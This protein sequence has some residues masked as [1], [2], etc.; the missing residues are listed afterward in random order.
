[1]WESKGS[2]IIK[3]ILDENNI[4][5]KQE[6]KFKDCKINKNYHLTFIE[7]INTCI[8]FD[9]IQHYK[10]VLFGGNENEITI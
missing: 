2:K 9:G 8:E 7:S 1:V 6:Y 10:S 5:Y 4:K 3:S